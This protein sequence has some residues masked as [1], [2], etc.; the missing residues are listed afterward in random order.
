MSQVRILIADD[1]PYMRTAYKRI[2]DTQEDFQVVGMAADGKEALEKAIA[3]VPD[4]AILDIRMPKM[5]G[6]EVSHW[7][8]DQHPLT[9]IVLISAYDDL[10]FVSAIMK[11]GAN[12]KA[13]LMKSSLDDIGELIRVVEPVVQGHSVLDAHIV[14]KLMTVYNRQYA[15]PPSSFTTMEEEVLRLILEGYD[16]SYIATTLG[17]EQMEMGSIATSACAKLGVTEQN[18]EDRNH[19]ATQALINCCVN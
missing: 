18:D 5:D 14:E 15:Y 6:I 4:V 19:L 2:L 12:R 17:L 10:A 7:I 16:D 13:Y 11:N 9:G 1:N 8:T 3:L